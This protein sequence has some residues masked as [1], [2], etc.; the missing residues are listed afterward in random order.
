MSVQAASGFPQQ[1]GVLIPQVW[2]GKMLVEFYEVTCLASITNS[3][4]EGEIK[5]QGDTVRIR[6]LPDISVTNYVKGQ[7]VNYE[8]PAEGI[9]ELLIDKA[10]LWAFRTDAV[11]E[12]QADIEFT[13][14]RVTHAGAKTAEAVEEDFFASIIADADAF[15]QG[16]SAGFRNRNRKLGALGGANGAN[17]V[18]LTNAPSGTGN[19]RNIIDFITDLTVVADE[20]KLP[21]ENRWLCL[22]SWMAALI[23]TSD[24][25]D[26]S[27]AGAGTISPLRNGFT[28]DVDG[29]SIYKTNQLY[30]VVDTTATTT[31]PTVTYIPF[32]HMSGITWAAQFTDTH[33]GVSERW[34]GRYFRGLTVY[35]H[36]TIKPEAFGT[37]I[38]RPAL[39]T[40]S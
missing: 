28:G 7:E 27:I 20:A 21:T 34:V 14:K 4:Y 9:S 1:S 38:V 17:H 19:K 6:S 30:S 8:L 31:T 13:S 26:A 32:G 11:D 25:K 23:R 39:S 40:D 22:P 37:A 36:E 15:N 10:K 18:G 12:K 24:L 16:N 29:W 3:D 5:A 2:S 35:G 33:S